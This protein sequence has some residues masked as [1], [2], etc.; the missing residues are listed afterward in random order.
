MTRNGRHMAGIFSW[1]SPR[2][3][4]FIPGYKNSWLDQKNH[5]KPYITPGQTRKTY[6]LNQFLDQESFPVLSHI[7]PFST[8]AQASHV[9][10]SW[11]N[12]INLD[13]VL[14]RDLLKSTKI[15]FGGKSEAAFANSIYAR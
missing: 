1:F 11:R 2:H 8:V 14:W 3:S 15:W 10:R 9:S 6:V 13:P 5:G 4:W 12:I 7:V